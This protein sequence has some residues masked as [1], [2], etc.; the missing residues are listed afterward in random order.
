MHSHLPLIV[1]LNFLTESRCVLIL[2]KLACQ[3]LDLETESIKYSVAIH[4]IHGDEES[5]RT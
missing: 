3:I 1:L 5:R 4:T 2:F